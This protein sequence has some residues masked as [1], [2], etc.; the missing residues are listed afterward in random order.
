MLDVHATPKVRGQKNETDSWA[1]IAALKA[2]R[3][4]EDPNEDLTQYERAGC[5]PEQ[6]KEIPK[7]DET[8]NVSYAYLRSI[9]NTWTY[10]P[11][12]THNKLKRRYYRRFDTFDKNTDNLMKLSE[13]YWWADRMKTVANCSSYEIEEVRAALKIF[14]EA[15]GLTEEGLRRENWVEANQVCAEAERERKKRGQASLVAVLGN[16]YFDVL[17]TDNNG[18]VTMPE[19]RQMMNVFHVPEDAAFAFFKHADV[20]GNGVLHRDEMHD[21]F[22]KFWMSKYDKKYDGIYGYQY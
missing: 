4:A 7:L 19:L 16:A 13:V 9:G 17:D 1:Q 10:K 21:M 6:Q 3:E 8:N 15:C 2:L 22:I 11:N 14:F 12:E 18:L 20:D 5:T